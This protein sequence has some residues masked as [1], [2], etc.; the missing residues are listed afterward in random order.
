MPVIIIVVAVLI[1]IWSIWSNRQTKL[2]VAQNLETMVMNVCQN[3]R[4]PAA[5]RWANPMVK[6]AFMGSIDMLCATPT[7]SISVGVFE[8]ETG[9]ENMLEARIGVDGTIVMRLQVEYLS[10]DA[11]IVK[12]WS[13]E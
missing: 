9:T 4:P 1:L 10:S 3:Q 6:D 8:D 12:G 13:S 7:E 5:V 2:V 11:I